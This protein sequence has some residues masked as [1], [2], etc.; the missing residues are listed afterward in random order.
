[1]HV[2]V[3]MVLL[4]GLYDARMHQGP[5]VL[6]VGHHYDHCLVRQMQKHFVVKHS[7]VVVMMMLSLMHYYDH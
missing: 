6:S 4:V 2:H 1:V 5:L 3:M 7:A